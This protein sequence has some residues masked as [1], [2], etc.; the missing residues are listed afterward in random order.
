M[1]RKLIGYVCLLICSLLTDNAVAQMSL[2][3]PACVLQGVQY[4]YEIGN[5]GTDTSSVQFCITGGVIADTN[6]TCSKTGNFS[7]IRVIWTDSI[8]GVISVK[9][10]SD[11]SSL[12]VS[13]TTVLDAGEIDTTNRLQTV[14]SDSVP[15]SIHC[16]P[17]TG[18]N[19]NAVYVY[20]WQQSQDGV[21]WSD[22][23]G[24]VSGSLS[25]TA[26]IGQ[27]TYF[28]RKVIEQIS[29]TDGVSDVALIIVTQ[30][31]Q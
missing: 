21:G 29:R 7:F 25:F 13:V 27:S 12:N 30:P 15:P 24:A 19:C 9:S 6:A 28:R 2:S 10:T 17:S 20:Q 4:Q 1:Q 14:S 18:A 5:R 11:S 22:I 23:A 8:G 16:S 26:P 3:G 31:T